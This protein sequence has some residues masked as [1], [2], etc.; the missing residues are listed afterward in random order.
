MT[1]TSSNTA[2]DAPTI[3]SSIY[4]PY[5]WQSQQW[6]RFSHQ[7]QQHRL[8]HAFLLTGPLGLGLEK[9]ANAMANTLLCNTP[10]NNQACQSCRSCKLLEAGSHPNKFCIE[11]KEDS[12][13]IKMEQIRELQQSMQSTTPQGGNQVAVLTPA[14]ALIKNT[15]NAFL[16]HLEEPNDGTYFILIASS[17]S[18]LPATLRSRCQVLVFRA[19]SKNDSLEWLRQQHT[20]HFKDECFNSLLLDM[21][22][23]TPLRTLQFCDSSYASNFA[24][25]CQAL[26]NQ[27][28]SSL[29]DLSQAEQ[30]AKLSPIDV[31]DW[32]LLLAHRCCSNR[33][34]SAQN[35][36]SGAPSE[37]ETNFAFARPLLELL[38]RTSHLPQRW[39]HH[40]HD[41]L[42][43]S[44][45]YYLQGSNQNQQLLIDELWLDWCAILSKRSKTSISSRT[46]IT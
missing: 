19:P 24:Q 34:F 26:A 45:K 40:F 15:A 11:P 27:S 12:R 3:D 44:K 7:H 9:F 37:V 2:L 30:V 43:Q 42:L 16:K 25:F 22:G 28:C 39:I 29:P 6:S 17:P 1:T 33:E 38:E 35:L 41:K 36:I 8:A 13:H 23:G 21:A 14:E 46:S 18:V 31:L 20:D 4:P 10:R 5:P 32:W